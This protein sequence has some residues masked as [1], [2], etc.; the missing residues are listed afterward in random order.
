MM[1][2]NVDRGVIV[3]RGTFPKDAIET[4]QPNDRFGICR[5]DDDGS[6]KIVCVSSLR[7]TEEDLEEN[8]HVLRRLINE[9][10]LSK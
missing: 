2:F 9:V 5:F 4:D 8:R 6:E 1:A 3:Y 7:P 10:V